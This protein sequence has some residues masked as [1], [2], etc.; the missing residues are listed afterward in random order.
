M[1]LLTLIGICLLIGLG[2][3]KTFLTID[4]Q[5]DMANSLRHMVANFAQIPNMANLSYDPELERK[6][7]SITCEHHPTGP[8]TFFVGPSEKEWQKIS[9]PQY[10]QNQVNLR[11]LAEKYPKFFDPD[12]TKIGCT[13]L[14]LKC[15]DF[16]CLLGPKSDEQDSE[17][18]NK[19]KR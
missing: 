15:F 2:Q 6:A 17:A 7:K 8:F 3:G 10:L 11:S 13:E 9:N 16:V 14:K 5:I 18:M 12:Q 19:K 1:N 4:G